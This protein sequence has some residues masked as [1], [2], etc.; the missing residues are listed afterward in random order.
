MSSAFLY[1]F[2]VYI[3]RQGFLMKAERTDFAKLTG[4]Q[5]PG[6]PVSPFSAL[7]LRV[8]VIGPGFYVGAVKFL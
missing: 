8:H 2:S 4:L 6:T 3:L 5:A 1:C 7:G